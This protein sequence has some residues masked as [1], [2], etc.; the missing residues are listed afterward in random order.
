MRIFQWPQKGNFDYEEWFQ[1]AD[2]GSVPLRVVAF[3]IADMYR[4]LFEVRGESSQLA[5]HSSSLFLDLTV[6]RFLVLDHTASRSVVE[7]NQSEMADQTP[8]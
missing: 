5:F 2:I 7:G 6:F 3:V 4:K 1:S 8:R